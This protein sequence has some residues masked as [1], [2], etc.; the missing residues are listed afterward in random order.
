MTLKQQLNQAEQQYCSA[1]LRYG[2][3]N[4]ETVRLE[5]RYRNLQDAV[6]AHQS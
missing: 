4:L 2:P 1:L 6:A 3:N 5:I